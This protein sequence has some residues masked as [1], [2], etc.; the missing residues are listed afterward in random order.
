MLLLVLVAGGLLGGGWSWWVLRRSRRALAEARGEIKAGRPGH[1]ARTLATL[2][3]WQ[4]D[5]DEAA[6]LL[7]SCEQAR[8][9]TQAASAAWARVPPGSPFA[10]RA[11]QGRVQL[12]IDHGR[13]ARAEQLLTDA[14]N[15]PGIDSSGLSLVLGLLEGQQGRVAEAEQL[16][17]ASW[18]RLNRAGKGASERAIHHVRLH[19]RLRLEPLPVEA[20]RAF[21]DQAERRAPADDRIWLAR[22]NLAIRAGAHD[23]AARW[24]EACLRRRP[25]N[26]PVWRARLSL[27][28]AM[29]RIEAVRQAALHLPAE[30][31]TEAEVDRL[32]AWLAARR[33]DAAAERTAL[34]RLIAADP[35][36]LT[37]L[38]RLAEL[39]VKD[40][41]PDRA[42]AL[43]RAKAELPQVQARY[44][45]LYQ[46]NQPFRDAVEMA[47]LAAQLGQR[48]EAKA[49]LTIAVAAELQPD[50]LRAELARL[51][52]EDRIT[53]RPGQT[54]AEVLAPEL[55]ATDP[56]SQ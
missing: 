22:A 24:L 45:E 27:A 34:G 28:V 11:I 44:Q 38:D 25:E 14:Q 17:A 42:A 56:P 16:I 33:G 52:L 36:D 6:Y 41:Q 48:F 3:A 55:D 54:L 19:L 21:V 37:A 18:D 8:G 5:S 35:A 26:P 43:R 30:L 49:F 51:D 1:A 46:R 13:L 47:R 2:L 40:G 10:P 20:V 15:D 39:A 53:A 32:A 29:N 31:A 12:E 23:E 9:R 4:P 7:G 50:D